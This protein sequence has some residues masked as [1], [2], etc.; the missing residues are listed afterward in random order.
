MLSRGCEED[1]EGVQRGCSDGVGRLS[2]GRGEVVYWVKGGCLEG[3]GRF[4]GW[5]WEVF[6]RVYFC[7]HTNIIQDLAF[8]FG[9]YIRRV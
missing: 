5:S 9:E 3:E 8:P 2:G 4:F 7:H 6:W 1:V